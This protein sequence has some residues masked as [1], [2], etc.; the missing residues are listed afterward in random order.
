MEE[1]MMSV[2]DAEAEVR[3]V[4]DRFAHF[5]YHVVQN[6]IREYGEEQAEK[7]IR[8]IVKDFGMEC[9]RMTRERVESLGHEPTLE[10]HHL[11]KDLPSLTFRKRKLETGKENEKAAEVTFCPYADTWKKLG[12][13]K[14]GRLYCTIDQ[15]KYKG[16]NEGFSCFHDLNVLDGDDRCIV[17]VVKG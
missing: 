8:K 15:A 4:I 14:W 2:S 12:F 16:Y 1:K 6:L 11:G 13:E 3:I 9:G 7:M 5:Y 10:N 17:R